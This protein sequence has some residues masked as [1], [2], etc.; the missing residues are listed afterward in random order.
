MG[1]PER[2]RGR[3]NT[4]LAI[5][6]GDLVKLGLLKSKY[7]IRWLEDVYFNNWGYLYPRRVEGYYSWSVDYRCNYD[8]EDEVI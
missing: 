5:H 8:E 1:L 3:S 4:F 7:G 6:S 2:L